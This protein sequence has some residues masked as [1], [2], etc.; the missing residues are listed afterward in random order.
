MAT[1]S[2]SPV[3]SAASDVV[4]YVLGFGPLGVGIVL[5]TCGSSC[6]ERP[7]TRP[8]NRLYTDSSNGPDG[9]AG[10]AATVEAAGG[11]PY[12]GGWLLGNGDPAW[13][14]GQVVLE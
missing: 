3:S 12:D 14:I 4:T 8:G 10:Y 13:L 11:T 2:I 5:Y 7:S 1:G 9:N 6:R